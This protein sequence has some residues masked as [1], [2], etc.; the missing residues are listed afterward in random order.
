MGPESM[1]VSQKRLQGYKT[2]LKRIKSDLIP[3]L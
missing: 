1:A 2:A 3:H